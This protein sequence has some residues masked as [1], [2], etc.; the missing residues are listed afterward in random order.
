[1]TTQLIEFMAFISSHEGGACAWRERRGTLARRGRNRWSPAVLPS[2]LELALSNV[3]FESPEA[4][5]AATEN[6]TTRVS[7]SH[8]R[9]RIGCPR[10]ELK[11]QI[12]YKFGRGIRAGSRMF[13]ATQ[14]V[15]RHG[16]S[17]QHPSGGGG[18]RFAK[19]CFG[20][21][22]IRPRREFILRNGAQTQHPPLFAGSSFCEMVLQR[23]IHPAAGSSFCE[24]VL[25]R[26]IRP[27]LAEVRFAKWCLRA[28]RIRPWRKFVLRD[29]AP[30]SH[31]CVMATPSMRS[32]DKSRNAFRFFA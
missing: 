17:T 4:A 26:N 16:A 30:A 5:M 19:W 20:A 3:T 12:I 10:Q 32:H 21:T 25:K 27:C 18:V 6:P 24:M 15:L 1:M 28:T 23:N 13:P 9:S 14:F 2:R 11:I 22:P 8:L 31:P 29:G 7:L